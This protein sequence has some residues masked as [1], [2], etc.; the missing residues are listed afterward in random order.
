MPAVSIIVPV[1]NSAAFLDPC[2]GS[3][4]SQTLQ[5][6]EFICIDDGSTDGSA[7]ILQAWA[8]KDKR[9]RI[10]SFTDNRGPSAARNAG[11]DAAR[12]TFVGFVDSDDSVDKDFFEKL[13]GA[14]ET[15]RADVAKGTLKNYDPVKGTVYL[16]EIFNLNYRIRRHKAWFYM[17]YTSA[18]YRTAMLRRNG[19]RFNEDLRFFEDPHFSIRAA[20]CYDT[21]VTVDD[22]CY[23]YTDNPGSVTHNERGERPVRDLIA[24]AAD[25]LDMMDRLP[26]VDD[27]H[28]CIVFAFLMDQFIGWCQKYYVP[29]EMTALS[30]SGFSSILKRCRNLDACMAEYVFFRKESDRKNLFR[31]IKRDLN[32]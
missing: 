25:L 7:A 30:S 28:Y 6:L 26:Q 27:R 10:L 17:T 5:D 13:Y 3:L 18:I 1:Y 2:L 16:K 23:Y 32:G 29:D 24:G 21:I 31:Q 9:F 22:A 19:I 8:A 15:T 20:F 11:L 12:G 14:A 4:Q